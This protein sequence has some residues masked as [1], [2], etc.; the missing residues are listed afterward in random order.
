MARKNYTVEQIIVKL[1]KEIVALHEKAV[2]R[3][4]LTAH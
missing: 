4:L 3:F 1:R 2:L